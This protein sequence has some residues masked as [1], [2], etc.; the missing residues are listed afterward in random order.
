[1]NLKTRLKELAA[2]SES[3]TKH[4]LGVFTTNKPKYGEA[5][6]FEGMK[7]EMN[8]VG[9]AAAGVGV[10]G[11]AYGAY[12]GHNAVMDKFAVADDGFG[13]LIRKTNPGA[14]GDAYRAAGNAAAGFAKGKWNKG[15]RAGG[16]GIAKLLAKLRIK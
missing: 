10:G 13:N 4:E 8:P 14:T 6:Q 15:V 2:K 16:L 12:A 7:R 9:A 1:M 5:G 11:A 3:A